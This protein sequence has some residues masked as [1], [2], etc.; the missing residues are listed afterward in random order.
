MGIL[1]DDEEGGNIFFVPFFSFL[2]HKTKSKQMPDNNPFDFMSY[3]NVGNKKQ[4]SNWGIDTNDFLSY[5]R[6][7]DQAMFG[8]FTEIQRKNKK[9]KR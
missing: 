7:G 2:Y 6:Q 4:N 1:H 9:G 8:D 5:V 3:L